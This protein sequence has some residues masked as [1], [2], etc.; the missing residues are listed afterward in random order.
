M[1]MRRIWEFY[2]FRIFRRTALQMQRRD[3]SVDKMLASWKVETTILSYGDLEMEVLQD[4][5]WGAQQESMT[6][7]ETTLEVIRSAGQ[8]WP[9]PLRM[10][11]KKLGNSS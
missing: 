9:S 1:E 8:W 11:I 2:H 5:W 3:E 10:G 4:F 7:H 6:L